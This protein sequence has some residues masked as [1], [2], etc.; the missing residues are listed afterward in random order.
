M[1]EQAYTDPEKKEP[2]CMACYTKVPDLP[3]Q[4]I[5]LSQI[6]AEAEEDATISAAERLTPNEASWLT[7][8]AFCKRCCHLKQ[9]LT[10]SHLSC[11]GMRSRG[12]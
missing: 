11:L 5:E 12:Y 4:V 9:Q 10:S 3:K 2:P 8:Q 6:E 7:M 1:R